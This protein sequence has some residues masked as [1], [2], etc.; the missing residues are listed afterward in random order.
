MEVEAVKERQ[1]TLFNIIICNNLTI[2]I[3]PYNDVIDILITSH[4]FI[5][6]KGH[7]G[8]KYFNKLQKIMTH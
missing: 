8:T 3:W 2:N 4:H 6:Y 1:N 7:I 5:W